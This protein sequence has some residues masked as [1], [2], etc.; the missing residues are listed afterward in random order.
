[1]FWVID[2]KERRAHRCDCTT[3]FYGILFID[4]CGTKMK[5]LV[6]I[7]LCQLHSNHDMHFELKL[8][9]NNVHGLLTCL[10]KVLNIFPS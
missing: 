9:H 8:I 2:I 1:M 10:W 7:D 3:A 6:L 4:I 5:Y